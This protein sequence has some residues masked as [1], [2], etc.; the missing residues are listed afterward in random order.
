MTVPHP[1]ILLRE[2][3]RQAAKQFR[4]SDDN[5][6][7]LFHPKGGFV[8]GYDMGLVEEAL[9]L[10]EVTLPSEYLAVDAPATME[11]QL[12]IDAARLVETSESMEVR[13]FAREVLAYL[14]IHKGQPAPKRKPF[15]LAARTDGQPL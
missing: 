14:V 6:T 7:S 8:Y 13:D 1:Y 2:Q 11:S 3:V 5:S 4:R 9:D 10:Y 12:L 15:V